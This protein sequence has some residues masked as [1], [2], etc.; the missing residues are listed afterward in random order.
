MTAQ[1]GRSRKEAEVGSRQRCFPGSPRERM[2]MV[3]QWKPLE[4]GVWPEWRCLLSKWLPQFAGALGAGA[5]VKGNE[6]RGLI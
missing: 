3:T 2:L 1:G 5:L 4:Q 6:R